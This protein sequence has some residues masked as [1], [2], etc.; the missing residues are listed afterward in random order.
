MISIINNK[1][2]HAHGDEESMVAT[3]QKYTDGQYVPK[4]KLNDIT[5]DAPHTL[6]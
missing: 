6:Q 5:V 2:Y 3:L 4:D 1:Q